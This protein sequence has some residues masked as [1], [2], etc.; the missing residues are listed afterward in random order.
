MSFLLVLFSFISMKRNNEHTDIKGPKSRLSLSI[1][2]TYALLPHD[3]DLTAK[4]I[5]SFDNTLSAYHANNYI[6]FKT[7]YENK[8]N[9]FS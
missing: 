1:I 9:T 5:I 6:A 8:I 4:L 7:K 2:L 3:T